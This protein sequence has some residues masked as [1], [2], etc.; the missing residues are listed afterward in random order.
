MNAN[1]PETADSRLQ[2]VAGASP[3]AS[4]LALHASMSLRVAWASTLEPRKADRSPMALRYSMRVA[5][6][7]R[8]RMKASTTLIAGSGKAT[9]VALAWMR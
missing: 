8:P 4:M 3:A 1:R 2:M 9:M 5:S 6:V 7:G